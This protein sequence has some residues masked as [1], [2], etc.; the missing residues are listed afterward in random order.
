M[1]TLQEWKVPPSSQPRAQDYSYD[2]ERALSSILGV[3]AI[4][5]PDAFTAD[6][7]GEE[8]AG[9]GVLIDDGLVLT[10]GYLITEAE[11]IWLHLG[12]GTVVPGHALGYDQETG[13]G[14]VQAL[15][16]IDLP[17][18]PLGSSD[19]IEIGERVVVGG[20]GG[21]TRSVAARIAARQEFAGY[22]EYVLDE[23]IF[24]YPA[25]PNWGGTGLIS[26]QGELIGIGSLQVERERDGE[27]EHLNMIVPIDLLK[28][29]LDDLRKFGRVNK[30]ARPWLGLYSTEI[31]DKIVIVGIAP[32]GP[33]SRAELKTGDVVLEVAGESVTTLGDFYRKVWSLGPAGVEIPLTLYRDGVT[34]EVEV[35]SSERGKFLKVP[36]MH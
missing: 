22:W 3:H 31:E 33:A 27:N 19:D 29:I 11:T 18:L 26:P 14:L 8:R 13:F 24:T 16:Q 6:T 4:I 32:K 30:P 5:P 36:R 34:F 7:L 21:R 28:P 25:H 35:N 9:N 20:A 10:V 17:S 12:D 23:A 15:G 2:L 1:T